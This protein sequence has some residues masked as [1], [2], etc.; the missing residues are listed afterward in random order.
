[1]T[2]GHRKI[3]EVVMKFITRSLLFLLALYGLVF[4]VGD[5]YLVRSGA[6]LWFAV[7]FAIG[8]VGLQYL[9]APW[10]IQWVLD[11]SWCDEG[12]KL[13]EANREFIEKLCAERG[14]KMPRIGIIYSGTPNAFYAATREWW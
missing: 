12:A 9:V 6:N 3:W 8:F 11:I 13:P 2:R 4:A 10:I 1:M 5:W 7:L 14:L